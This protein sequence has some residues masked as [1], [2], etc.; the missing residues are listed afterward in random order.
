MFL[1]RA[2]GARRCDFLRGVLLRSG[3]GGMP[4]DASRRLG[5]VGGCPGGIYR[6]ER[7]SSR[8]RGAHARVG[9]SENERR[10]LSP[11][12]KAFRFHRFRA[13]VDVR[14]PPVPESQGSNRHHLHGRPSQIL[15]L[16]TASFSDRPN[17]IALV[18][19]RVSPG[20]R[21]V[22]LLFL[23]VPSRREAHHRNRLSNGKGSIGRA[24]YYTLHYKD[25]RSS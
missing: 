14:S 3:L 2:G 12:S 25:G 9:R 4:R 8:F 10:R 1:S 11:R 17:G 18:A 16:S 13:N 20:H 23:S 6:T 22:R 5:R 24:R 15:R 21:S 7:L 19:F